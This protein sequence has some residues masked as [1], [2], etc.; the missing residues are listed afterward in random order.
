MQASGRQKQCT[1]RVIGD[2]SCLLRFYWRMMA[3][4]VLVFRSTRGARRLRGAYKV[5]L[6]KIIV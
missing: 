6:H 5:Y 1:G 3:G 4:F 2:T